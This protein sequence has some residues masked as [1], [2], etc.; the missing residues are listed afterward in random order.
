VA[1]LVKLEATMKAI[2]SP[3][4]DKLVYLLKCLDIKATRN[5]FILN[6]TSYVAPRFYMNQSTY[7]SLVKAFGKTK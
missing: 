3:E 4:M 5:V 2:D 1:L 7:D 6:G